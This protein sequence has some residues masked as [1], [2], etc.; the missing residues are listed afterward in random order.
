MPLKSVRQAMEEFQ[1][2]SL[3]SGKGGPLVQSR[4]QAIAIGLSAER[5]AKHGKK[6]GKKKGA[7]AGMLKGRFHK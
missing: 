7:I 6:K 1:A 4:R 5:R 3:H 2:G